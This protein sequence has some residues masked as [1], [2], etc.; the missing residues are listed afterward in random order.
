M[1]DNISTIGHKSQFWRSIGLTLV[2][3]AW[4]L[5]KVCNTCVPLLPSLF[6]KMK[7]KKY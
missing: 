7:I 3:I 1:I 5:K 4:E 6:Q 2:N